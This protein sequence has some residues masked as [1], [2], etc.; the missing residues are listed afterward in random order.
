MHLG[1]YPMGVTR[2]MAYAPRA[3]MRGTGNRP[4]IHGVMM[5]R[6]Y[7]GDLG[8][9]PQAQ[10]AAGGAATGAKIGSAIMPGVGT[11][12]GAVV[13]GIAGAIAGR[14]DPNKAE[15]KVL[16]DD[17]DQYINLY[18]GR[19]PGRAF[20]A[21]T[22]EKLIDAAGQRK[23]WPNVKKWSGDAIHGAIYGCK[24]CTPPT[25]VEWVRQQVAGGNLNPTTLV[26][27]WGAL[28]Q[29]TWGSKWF[30]PSGNVQRQLIIDLLDALI[31]QQVPNAPQFYAMPEAP[32]APVASVPSAPPPAV[33]AP[34]PP[35]VLPPMATLPHFLPMPAP[36]MPVPPSAASAMATTT[37]APAQITTQPTSGGAATL[38]TPDITAQV[39]SAVA[40]MLAQGASPPTAYQATVDS[41][42]SQGVAVTP[43]VQNAVAQ[44]VTQASA[45]GGGLLLAGLAVGAFVLLN[46]GSGKRAHA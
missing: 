27:P 4:A 3:R 30:V 38:A 20:G 15:K 44:Q 39:Q 37:S 24:G 2:A 7:L 21:Q 1:Y 28:V 23:M 40:N 31:A 12:I 26:D 19:V 35:P 5:R 46:S 18:M 34:V 17:L 16:S 9:S 45:G 11:A 6:E 10:G 22:M 33:I 14:G 36:A 42:A 8:L 29:R 43:D 13:G 41:L 32:P 25:V